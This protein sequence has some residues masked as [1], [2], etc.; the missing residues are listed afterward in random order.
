MNSSNISMVYPKIKNHL[1]CPECSSQ[2]T[3][4][5]RSNENNVLFIWYECCKDECSGQ[6]LQKECQKSA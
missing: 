4:V 6:W 3:E 5:Y 1:S 2:M